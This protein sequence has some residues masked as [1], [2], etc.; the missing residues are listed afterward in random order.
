VDPAGE[1]GEGSRRGIVRLRVEGRL[2]V[3]A[4]HVHAVEDQRVQV[5]VEVETGPAGMGRTH[6]AAV[7]GPRVRGT[8][9]FEHRDHLLHDRGSDPPQRCA[10][11]GE[12]VP[13]RL[14]Q[15]DDDVPH[16]HAREDVEDRR[17]LAL[18]PRTA[19]ALRGAGEPQPVLA[20]AP[21]AVHLDR[22]GAGSRGSV[23]GL[24]VEVEV[25]LHLYGH[26]HLSTAAADR[27]RF[28]RRVLAGVPTGHGPRV[29]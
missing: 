12:G 28:L 22:A 25:Q 23:L 11:M 14:G 7:H 21:G 19:P 9:L 17:H 29:P 13:P 20:S 18:L 10:V 2:A 3:F 24:C 16:G 8:G 27:C 26:A 5:Q 1:R 15:R 4:Q 6:A